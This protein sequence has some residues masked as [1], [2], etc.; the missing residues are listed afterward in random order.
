LL[1]FNEIDGM[2]EKETLDLYADA[3]KG[4][5]CGGNGNVYNPTTN[6]FDKPR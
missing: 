1:Y 5:N 2:K 6:D 3:L 4:A